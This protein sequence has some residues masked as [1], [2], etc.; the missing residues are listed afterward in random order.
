[1]TFF[2]LIFY[3]R[4]ITLVKLY[5]LTLVMPDNTLGIRNIYRIIVIL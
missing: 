1:M 3:K 5:D 4:L 2:I